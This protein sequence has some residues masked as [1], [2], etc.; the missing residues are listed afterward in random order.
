IR[1]IEDIAC[2][3]E[4]FTIDSTLVSA[5]LSASEGSG[6]AWPS[7]ISSGFDPAWPSSRVSASILVWPSA[8]APGSGPAWSSS[9]PPSVALSTT[10]SDSSSLSDCPSTSY[11]DSSLGT[12]SASDAATDFRERIL[13][14]RLCLDFLALGGLSDIYMACLRFFSCG[15][16]GADVGA[17]C[18]DATRVETEGIRGAFCAVDLGFLAGLAGFG[19]G[20]MVEEVVK[21]L[22]KL[23][24]TIS[25]SVRTGGATAD[26]D[27]RCKLLHM[28]YSDV[29]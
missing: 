12:S 22:W 8:Y 24:C 14:T 5:F 18:A 27:V 6:P 13:D 10:F 15:L 23:V 7:D 19:A 20:D 29:D 26:G 9:L 21:A 4:T 16:A 11:G 25:S 3:I 2:W 1:E 28:S 17:G